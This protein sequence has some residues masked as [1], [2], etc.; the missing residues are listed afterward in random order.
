MNIRGEYIITPPN[1]GEIILPNTI[2]AEGAEDFLIDL[3][4]AAAALPAAFY[5]GL[6]DQVPDNADTLSSITTEPTIGVNGYARGVLTRNATDWP[7]ITTAGGE[8]YVE[9]K[10]VDFTASG[11]DFDDN[12]SRLFM[13]SVATGF[14]GVLY[15]Y[16]AALS[17]AI[18][19]TSGVT[20]SA[21]Y[22]M[23]LS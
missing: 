12:H 19:I 16:S 20:W 17:A 2:V 4:Q 14:V 11:G 3:F 5:I 6:C 23:F 21:K 10:Q 8:S 22:R 13:C 18:T 1:G 7:T 9:S 15:S